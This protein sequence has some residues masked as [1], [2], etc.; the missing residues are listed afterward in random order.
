MTSTGNTC[1]HTDTLPD[2]TG[3][4]QIMQIWPECV[5]RNYRNVPKALSGFQK[6]EEHLYA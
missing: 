2:G 6:K 5:D 4:D 3:W 1:K